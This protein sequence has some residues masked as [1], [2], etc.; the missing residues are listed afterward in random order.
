MEEAVPAVDKSTENP[1]VQLSCKEQNNKVFI[2]S[3][4]VHP[5][6]CQCAND[7]TFLWEKTHSAITLSFQVSITPSER[8][9]QESNAIQSVTHCQGFADLQS[10]RY[11]GARLD[12]WRADEQK[13]LRCL[14]ERLLW[15]FLTQRQ[16]KVIWHLADGYQVLTVPATS[17]SRWLTDL[18]GLWKCSRCRQISK[19]Y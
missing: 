5:C 19:I 13:S 1:T 12:R 10:F 16:S 17:S 6:Y 18:L 7:L 3:V 4:F 11:Q 14:S 2:F 15:V 8:F 9:F